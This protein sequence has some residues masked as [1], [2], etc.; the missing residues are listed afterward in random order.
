MGKPRK[1]PREEVVRLYV[2]QGLATTRIAQM[3]G[4]SDPCTVRT[5]L[6]RAGVVLRTHTV[7][8]IC[9]EEGCGKP[10]FRTLHKANGSLYGN[11]CEGHQKQHRR[12]VCATWSKQFRTNNP[13]LARKLCEAWINR[14]RNMTPEQ[15]ITE[16]K[17]K[18]CQFKKEELLR[19]LRSLSRQGRSREAIE[20]VTKWIP[21]PPLKQESPRPGTWS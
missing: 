18:P 17:E 13:E 2:E 5:Q 3:F 7:R 19:K 15:L 1:L 21:S 6:L 12:K 10:V 8:Q 20:L 9:I 11:R 14:L 4:V 16:I